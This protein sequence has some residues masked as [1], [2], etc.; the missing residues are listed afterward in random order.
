MSSTIEAVTVASA[1]A[2]ICGLAFGDWLDMGDLLFPFFRRFQATV[3][4]SSYWELIRMTNEIDNELEARRA[5]R[6]GEDTDNAGNRFVS[7]PRNAIEDGP[8]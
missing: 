7:I 1:L 3:K 2:F 5:S 6:F 8:Y 4:R